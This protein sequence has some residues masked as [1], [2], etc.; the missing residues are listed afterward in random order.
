MPT[1]SLTVRSA[2]IRFALAA[3]AMGLIAPLSPLAQTFSATTGTDPVAMATASSAHTMKAKPPKNGEDTLLYG[4][5]RDGVYTVDGMVA[6]IQLNYDVNGALFL[7]LFVP[8]VGTAVVSPVADPEAVN[9][10]A[11]LHE[12]ELKF[13][14]GDHRFTLTGVALATGKGHE[15]EHL[16]VKLDRSAWQ[17]SRHPMMGFGNAAAMPYQWPGALAAP[18]AA[19]QTEESQLVPPP[20]AS[21]LPSTSAVTPAPAAPKPVSLRPV[22]M[23]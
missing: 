23:Q 17:L 22:A 9:T 8:G 2:V 7:Y 21:L 4:R 14:V 6:K 18:S 1:S 3:V 10:E 19:A 11:K 15:P 20:P 5:V 12:N 13:S 16:Y